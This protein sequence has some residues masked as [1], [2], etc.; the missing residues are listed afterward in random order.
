MRFLM[1][2]VMLTALLA[3]SSEAVEIS[4]V[5]IYGKIIMSADY[6]NNGNDGYVGITSSNSRLGF[7]GHFILNEDYKA[8]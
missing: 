2:T 4:P 5:T 6:A 8:I 1:L 7:K 3:A